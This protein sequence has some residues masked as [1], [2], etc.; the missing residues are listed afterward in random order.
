[1][2]HIYETYNYININDVIIIVS[3]SY[4]ERYIKNEIDIP[5]LTCSSSVSG[6]RAAS[7]LIGS[8]RLISTFERIKFIIIDII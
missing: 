3:N 6:S 2:K 5:K 7:G 1:M 4:V 8:A